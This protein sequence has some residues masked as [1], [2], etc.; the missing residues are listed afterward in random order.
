MLITPYSHN[1][2]NFYKTIYK[3]I[4][5]PIFKKYIEDVFA[6]QIYSLSNHASYM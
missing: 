3:T 6:L 4:Y 5:K 2:Y 1:F